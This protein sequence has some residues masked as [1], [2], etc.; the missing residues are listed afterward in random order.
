MMDVHELLKVKD[1]LLAR[2]HGFTGGNP[3]V[4]T[5]KPPEA[6]S[7]MLECLLAGWTKCVH[8]YYS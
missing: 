8:E 3:I 4:E 6:R 7:M 5:I 1:L 2:I